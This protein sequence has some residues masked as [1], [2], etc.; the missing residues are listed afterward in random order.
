MRGIGL[1]DTNKYRLGDYHKTRSKS[2]TAMSA[3]R[4]GDMPTAKSIMR[5]VKKR[6]LRERLIEAIIEVFDDRYSASVFSKDRR[7]KQQGALLR[8]ARKLKAR[9]ARKKY[10]PETSLGNYAGDGTVQSHNW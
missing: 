2:D 4:A 7:K 10:A 3:I 9:A 1:R 8:K 6:G 5:H